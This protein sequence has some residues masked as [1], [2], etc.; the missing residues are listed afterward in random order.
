MG[1]QN[2]ARM[3]AIIKE[4]G[5]PSPTLVG[6]DGVEAAFLLVQHA[7]H[8][9]QKKN[10]PVILKA[11]RAGKLS[12][13]N[14][15]LF[16]DRVLVGDGE[17]QIYGTQA[18]SFTDWANQEPVLLPIKD[19]ASVDQRRKSIGLPPLSEYLKTLKQMYFPA[20]KSNP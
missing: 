17:P 16:L 3:A 20:E 12:G 11:Y 19:E 10:H 2:E 15:A 6:I 1:A 9:F 8:A 5:F 18:K 7:S 13:Q 14:Y 4:Y